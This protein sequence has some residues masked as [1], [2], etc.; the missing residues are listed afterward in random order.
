[1]FFGRKK[2]PVREISGRLPSELIKSRPKKV[3]GRGCDPYDSTGRNA[4]RQ[5]GLVS[6]RQKG[7]AGGGSSN[8]YDTAGSYGGSKD[9]WSGVRRGDYDR[10]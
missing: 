1:M 8:P 10:R 6:V 5:S 9:P 4:K 2:R 3:G 7:G